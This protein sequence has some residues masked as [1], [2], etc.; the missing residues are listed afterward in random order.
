MTV[1]TIVAVYVGMFGVVI[2]SFLNV[3]FRRIP[4]GVS[5]WIPSYCPSCRA[6][7]KPYDNI[8]IVSYCLL[9]GRC[10]NCRAPISIRYPLVEAGTGVV[11]LSAYFL[12][13]LLNRGA[14]TER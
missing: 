4:L 11:F 3:C 1:D 2:G 5:L 8:P 10:R 6:A 13:N 7:V 9:W 12:W 14:I